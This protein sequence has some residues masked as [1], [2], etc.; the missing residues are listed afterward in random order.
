MVTNYVL[1]GV[2]LFFAAMLVI[3]YLHE[4]KKKKH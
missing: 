3:M 4:P 2:I 1:A